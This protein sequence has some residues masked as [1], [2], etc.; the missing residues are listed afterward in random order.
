MYVQEYPKVMYSWSKLVVEIFGF[1][2]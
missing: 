1:L 2:L